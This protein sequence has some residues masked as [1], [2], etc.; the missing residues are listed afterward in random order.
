[1]FELIYLLLL[2]LILFNFAYF[3]PKNGMFKELYYFLSAILSSL[4]ALHNYVKIAE[5]IRLYYSPQNTT[6]EVLGLLLIFL[7]AQIIFV[8]LWNS[9]FEK[10]RIIKFLEPVSKVFGTIYGFFKGVTLLSFILL[11]IYK[12]PLPLDLREPLEPTAK[13]QFVRKI[14]LFVPNLYNWC[15]KKIGLNL[16]E[17][18]I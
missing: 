11:I 18:L 12:L 16:P 8:S 3:G 4:A 1:M 15:I 9:Y 2:G 10:I 6:P 5:F 14:L 7:L 17:F 13:T